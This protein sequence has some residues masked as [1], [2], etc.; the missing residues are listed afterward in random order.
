[1]KNNK[2]QMMVCL[3]KRLPSATCGKY[4]ISIANRENVCNHH[5]HPGMTAHLFRPKGDVSH[6]VSALAKELQ[7]NYSSYLNVN[8]RFKI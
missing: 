5:S 2:K 7:S 1:M 4:G 6:V 3:K 8:S